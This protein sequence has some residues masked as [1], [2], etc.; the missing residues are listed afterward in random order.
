MASIWSAIQQGLAGTGIFLAWSLCAALCLGGLL[1]SVLSFSGTWLILAAAGVATALTGPEQFPGWA[2]L[3]GFLAVCASVDLIEWFA[4]GWGVRRRGGSSAASWM[5]L[6][7]SLGGMILGTIFIPIP[8]LGGLVG[9]MTGSFSLVYWIEN[10]RLKKAAHA[11]HIA[12]GAVMASMSV[13][14]LKVIATSTLIVWLLA[15]LLF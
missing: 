9:M 11:K 6:L 7:G 8:I 15:G 5:A 4:A 12:F 3:A 10:R 1:L 14:L 13:L 2:T